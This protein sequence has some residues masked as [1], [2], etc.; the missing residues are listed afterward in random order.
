[1][2]E[3]WR[4][5]CVDKRDSGWNAGDIV[6]MYEDGQYVINNRKR[7][8]SYNTITFNEWERY[9]FTSEWELIQPNQDTLTPEEVIGLLMETLYDNTDNYKK[10]KEIFGDSD[11][12]LRDLK[13]HDFTPSEIIQKLTDYKKSKQVKIISKQEYDKVASD[14]L[15]EIYPMG[16]RLE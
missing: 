2:N 5:R 15:D 6:T 11:F 3:L 13:Y 10:C 1:M 8:R 7:K 16:W 4:A 12:D 9:C 14:K